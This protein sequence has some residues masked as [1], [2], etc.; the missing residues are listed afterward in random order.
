MP[1]SAALGVIQNLPQDLVVSINAQYVERAPQAP[2][3]L[4]RGMHEATGTYDIGN[5]NLGIESAK[6][7]ELGFKRVTGPFR[8]EATA[9]YTSFGGFI[10]R[11]F[12]GQTCESGAGTCTPL[13]EG[14]D[15]NQAVYTQRDALF[16]GAEIQTQYDLT[17]IYNGV[18]GFENQFDVVRAT[19]FDGGNVPRIPPVRLGGGLFYRDTNWV[20]RVNLLHAFAQNNVAPYETP[21]AG[22]NLLKAEIS[23][24]TKLDPQGRREL[25][26]GVTG[27]NLLNQNI[28]NSVSFRKDQILLP[29]ANLRFIANLS[30]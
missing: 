28:R 2:E 23:Y 22:Y 25:M 12:T 21:T 27:N 30:F 24:K 16:R 3:L 10:Y 13:G 17:G 9:Y 11:N 15:L 6:Q 5:P 4:S 20:A 7:I 19:F 14:G 26:M 18:F 1:K 8:F 29:G